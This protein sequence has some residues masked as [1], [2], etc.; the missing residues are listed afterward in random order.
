[1]QQPIK[2]D[3]LTQTDIFMKDIKKIKMKKYIEEKKEKVLLQ[4]KYMKIPCSFDEIRP[5]LVRSHLLTII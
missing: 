2:L 3:A 5:F 4:K 1:M